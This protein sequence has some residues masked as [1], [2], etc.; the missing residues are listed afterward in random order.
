M[1]YRLNRPRIALV[2]AV[3]MDLVCL[4]PNRIQLS[5]ST[6]WER[7]TGNSGTRERSAH[8][9]DEKSL[10]PYWT[11]TADTHPRRAVKGP[12]RS[13]PSDAEPEV[14]LKPAGTHTPAIPAPSAQGPSRTRVT[15]CT[16]RSPSSVGPPKEPP[17]IEPNPAARSPFSAHLGP[18]ISEL[19][20]RVAQPLVEIG[21]LPF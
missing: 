13:L 4:I 21:K 8:L 7:E 5:T 2:S 16:L 17:L 12:A 1:A 6:E 14:G 9:A 15:P 18:R 10:N 19:A 11:R 3:R 20:L